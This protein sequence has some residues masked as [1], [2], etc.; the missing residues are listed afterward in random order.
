MVYNTYTIAA[1][2][3]SMRASYGFSGRLRSV[4]HSGAM[5][6]PRCGADVDPAQT[7]CV[8]CGAATP[9]AERIRA[10]ERVRQE[11]ATA[12]R[13]ESDR[14]QQTAAREKMETAATRS[15]TFALVGSVICLLP[16]FQIVSVIFYLRAR[17]FARQLSADLP[18]RATA[19]LVL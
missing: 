4:V 11:R 3:F 19:G 12:D 14:R 1:R 15:L 10:E 17:S 5:E 13:A 7:A 16:V 2:R 8:Y 9:N 18:M 6:C